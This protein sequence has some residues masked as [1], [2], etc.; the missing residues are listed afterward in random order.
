M[1]A[2]PPLVPKRWHNTVFTEHDDIADENEGLDFLKQN[3]LNE[4]STFTKAQLARLNNTC[5][6]Y[7]GDKPSKKDKKGKI[8]ADLDQFMND[9]DFMVVLTSNSM[10]AVALPIDVSTIRN[11]DLVAKGFHLPPL[12]T[13][14]TSILINS[15]LNVVGDNYQVFLNYDEKEFNNAIKS[16]KTMGR[17]MKK[18]NYEVLRPA[19]GNIIRYFVKYWYLHPWLSRKQAYSKA[20]EHLDKNYKKKGD[21]VSLIKVILKDRKESILNN[22]ALNLKTIPRAGSINGE[23]IFME[24]ETAQFILTN[25]LKAKNVKIPKDIPDVLEVMKPYIDTMKE[26]EKTTYHDKFDKIQPLQTVLYLE[27]KRKRDEKAAAAEKK[28]KEAEAVQVMLQEKKQKIIDDALHSDV[29]ARRDNTSSE[30]DKNNEEED[31]DEDYTV[32]PKDKFAEYKLPIRKCEFVAQ[33]EVKGRRNSAAAVRS[34]A[35]GN[36]APIKKCIVCMHG[37][38]VKVAYVFPGK[39]WK[40]DIGGRLF[41]ITSAF[42]QLWFVDQDLTKNCSKGV[43]NGQ[44]TPEVA[45]VL[46]AIMVHKEA[47]EKYE[48]VGLPE[49]FFEK[50]F[51]QDVKNTKEVWLPE[52]LAGDMKN[53]HGFY[54]LAC[55]E[56]KIATMT[57][58]SRL[59]ALESHVKDPG[60]MS[61]YNCKML[62]EMITVL[63]NLDAELKAMEFGT[64]E[65]I[66]DPFHTKSR[67]ASEE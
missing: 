35:V 25:F 44:L 4:S 42:K 26:P 7:G 22:Q 13:N 58:E 8:K 36:S 18:T 20:M 61:T 12:Q 48:Q 37:S 21:L 15:F 46:L 2:D 33:P 23:L 51:F 38:G 17:Y 65:H 57:K 3:K 59:E 5:G 66:V 11:Y 28:Q 63:Q 19:F 47:A 60:V 39:L 55:E 14:D 27:K 16:A 49:H 45:R 67:L 64:A 6:Y 24:N 52:P 40:K 43:S 50:N 62:E 54:Q 56:D 1:A 41:V 31:K 53:V 30:K 34:L 9:L 32:D 29:T 10:E